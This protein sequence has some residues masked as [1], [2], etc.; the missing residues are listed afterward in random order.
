MGTEVWE[1]FGAIAS[2]YLAPS[3]TTINYGDIP[4]GEEGGRGV[5]PL[6]YVSLKVNRRIAVVQIITIKYKRPQ[7]SHPRTRE[8]CGVSREAQSLTHHRTSW[9][10]RV[11]KPAD[12]RGTVRRT[13]VPSGALRK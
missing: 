1:N 4:S 12:R 8:D 3:H 6:R 11:T 13:D 10:V 2:T 9:N 5:P 7:H